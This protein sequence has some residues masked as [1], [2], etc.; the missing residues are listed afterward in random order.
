MA[1]I[2][3]R[4]QLI[5]DTKT[6]MNSTKFLLLHSCFEVE[7]LPSKQDE[8]WSKEKIQ[9][10]VTKFEDS[11]IEELKNSLHK[12]LEHLNSVCD[13]AKRALL[14][15]ELIMYIT[16]LFELVNHKSNKVDENSTVNE[17]I[18]GKT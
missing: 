7:L 9:K 10:P 15:H 11:V 14:L 17:F 3:R 18:H 4:P 2:I 8:F 12:T 16:R 13:S 1:T 6:F 5:E